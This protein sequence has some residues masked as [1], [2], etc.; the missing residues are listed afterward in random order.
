[1]DGYQHQL[2]RKDKVRNKKNCRKHIHFLSTAS[3]SV[4]SLMIYPL[5]IQEVYGHILCHSYKQQDAGV[6]E[7]KIMKKFF[8]QN[9]VIHSTKERGSID[10]KNHSESFPALC[11]QIHTDS[12][13]VSTHLNNIN[14]MKSFN[15]SI[16]IFTP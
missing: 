14:L 13:I 8:K 7:Q 1:M 11:H 5:H 16:K 3:K 10:Q 12:M 2:I 9:Q 4:H 15:Y 6:S